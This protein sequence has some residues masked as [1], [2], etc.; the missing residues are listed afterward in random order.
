MPLPGQSLSP[1][2]PLPCLLYRT[3]TNLLFIDVVLPFL[4]FRVNPIIEE[5]SNCLEYVTWLL[6]LRLVAERFSQ[7]V[8][9]SS[10][11][12]IIAESYPTL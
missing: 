1:P 10:S 9:V 11:L 12:L 2:R 5:M 7:V 6:S 8:R 3:V 4:E